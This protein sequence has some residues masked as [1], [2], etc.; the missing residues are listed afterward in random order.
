MKCGRY[1]LRG[2]VAVE[3][4]DVIAWA[5]WL[6]RA[7]RHV[8][9]TRL[10]RILVSTVFLGLDHNFNRQGHAPILYETM[11]FDDRPDPCA[12]LPGRLDEY[13]ER[14]S[15]WPEAEVGHDRPVELVRAWLASNAGAAP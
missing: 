13:C 15:T 5:D 9:I 10:D 2:H 6:E 12:P 7:E 4:P 1:I 8:G 14:Y 3:E 11:I